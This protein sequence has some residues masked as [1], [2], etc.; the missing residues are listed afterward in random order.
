M[1]D[2]HPFKVC[3]DGVHL[4]LVNRDATVSDEGGFRVV[5]VGLAV[6]VSVVSNLVVVLRC[7]NC[8]VQKVRSLDQTHPNCNPWELLVGQQEVEIRAVGSVPLPVIVECG[9]DALRLWHTVDT[10]SVAVVTVTSVLID[11]VT[12]V[13]HV[14]YGVLA[15]WVAKCVEEAEWEVAARVDG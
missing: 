12:N 11:V 3:A 15:S 1:A 14:V 6:T 9:N 10:V 4:A 13:Q 5:K 2:G 8:R 7:V